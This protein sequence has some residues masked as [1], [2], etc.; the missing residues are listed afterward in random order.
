[1]GL[2]GRPWARSNIIPMVLVKNKH[3]LV[4]GDAGCKK[5]IGGVSV[6]HARGSIV[7]RVQVSCAAGW[8][9]RRCIVRRNFFIHGLLLRAVLVWRGGGKEVL[10]FMLTCSKWSWRMVTEAGGYSRPAADA[11]PDQVVKWPASIAVHHVERAG[12]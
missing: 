10:V 3:V 12:E 7:I 8:W 1:M 4:A 2:C 9:L 6:D 5:S 11:R